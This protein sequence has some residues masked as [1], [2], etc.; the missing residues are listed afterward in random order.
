MSKRLGAITSLAVAG[1]LTASGTS[2][3]QG[4]GSNV[5][6]SDIPAD[7]I[8]RQVFNDA[9]SAGGL[10]RLLDCTTGVILY[11][12][13]DRTLT[14]QPLPANNVRAQEALRDI[15]RKAGKNPS[16]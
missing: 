5:S 3:A 1:F 10:T 4:L 2:V 6:P 15:C 11:S 13:G 14:S 16:F 7:P 8:V 12:Q 9:R